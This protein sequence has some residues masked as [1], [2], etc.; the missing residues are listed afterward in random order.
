MI[1]CG[2]KANQQVSG[3]MS[4]AGDL[5]AGGNDLA[6]SD[7]G[8]SPDLLPPGPP[9][10]Q[11]NGACALSGGGNGICKSGFCVGCAAPT[12]DPT[13]NTAYGSAGSSFVCIGG[14][15]AA[16]ACSS[17]SE[18]AAGQVCPANS[19]TCAACSANSDCTS[20]PAYGAGFICVPSG[21]NGSPKICVQG[22]C[23]TDADCP[24]GGLCGVNQPFQCAPCTSD[25][26]CQNDT[27]AHGG[28]GTI[29]NQSTGA[30]FTPTCGNNSEGASCT[31]PGDTN[32]PHVCCGVGTFSCLPGNC[33]GSGQSTCTGTNATCVDSATPATPAT[34]GYCTTCTLPGNNTFYVD[35]T[36][37]AGDTTGTGNNGQAGCDFQ[38]ITHALSFIHSSVANPATI[39]VL[40]ASGSLAASEKYPIQVP[41][42]VSIQTSGGTV[43]VKPNGNNSAFVFR[44]AGDSLTGFTLDGS[45][46]DTGN[47]V[48][49]VNGG[50]VT[51]GKLTVQNFMGDGIAVLAGGTANVG[52]GVVSSNNGSTG[53]NV[54]VSGLHVLGAATINNSGNGAVQTAFNSNSA[55]GILVD[56][57]GTLSVTGTVTSGQSGFTGTVVAN[58]NRIA[59]LF[60][61][62]SANGNVNQVTGLITNGSLAGNGIRVLGGSTLTL[63]SSVSLG[64][65]GNGVEISAG[66]N[67]NTNVAGIDLGSNAS[68]GLNVLQQ[69]T[70]Q[71]GGAGLC[72]LM[73]AV[74]G[75]PLNALGNKFT[76][77][78]CTM[79]GAGALTSDSGCSGHVDVGGLLKTSS[80]VKTMNV[81][82]CSY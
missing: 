76:A 52:G 81:T 20:D 3:D 12:D 57:A 82:T 54:A 29:C 62:S 44:G 31:A 80:N 45:G 27:G 11:L 36:N 78:D 56:G 6:S 19:H 55:H 59:G 63:R 74:T 46:S 39:I 28:A 32:N 26:Q 40:G 41:A 38:T 5:A 60:L 37:A 66:A 53:S 69:P 14:V 22:N 73:N 47:G 16:G 35:P 10:T 25:S 7:G 48:R 1:G 24:N 21:G 23:Q 79:Q 15:C 67:N 42:Y 58:N 4:T 49:V 68:N 70:A 51:L 65:A 72:L 61:S 8:A 71:N 34:P 2:T 17:G 13:C 43:T 75:G 64:N 33:C 77:Q 9:C 30:C 18:C 50:A